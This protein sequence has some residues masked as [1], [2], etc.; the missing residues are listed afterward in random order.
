MDMTITSADFPAQQ[1]TVEASPV[2]GILGF[3]AGC[4]WSRLHY[5]TEE[6]AGTKY[7]PREETSHVEEG[8]QHRAGYSPFVELEA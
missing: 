8:P 1:G 4:L 5:V 3:E 7:R 6:S 2:S